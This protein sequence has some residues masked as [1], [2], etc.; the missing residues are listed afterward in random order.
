MLLAFLCYIVSGR[1]CLAHQ[2][3][4]RHRDFFPRVS[5]CEDPFDLSIPGHALCVT[6]EIGPGPTTIALFKP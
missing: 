3:A 2:A 1:Q 4:H 5:T 6:R